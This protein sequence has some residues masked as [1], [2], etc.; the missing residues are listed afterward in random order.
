MTAATAPTTMPA[1]APPLGNES[2][3]VEAVGMV[4]AGRMLVAMPTG[5]EPVGSIEAAMQEVDDELET[6]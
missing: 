4:A 2:T 3:V 5:Q 1:M 6:W